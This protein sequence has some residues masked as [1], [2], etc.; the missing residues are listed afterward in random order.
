MTVQNCFSNT[1][2]G[3][4]L[5]IGSL[6]LMSLVFSTSAQS[7]EKDSKTSKLV[8]EWAEFELIEGVSEE[9][10]LKA[11]EEVQNT[12][13]KNQKGFVKRELL[14]GANNTWVDLVY[15]E[16]MEDAQRAVKNVANSPACLAYF[17]LMVSVDPDHPEAGI[18]H[19]E[20]W[21]TYD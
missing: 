14:K 5:V 3:Y 15:W 13:L 2:C 8:I 9:T 21:K 18:E 17:Q 12:F 1:V 11:S 6:I 4:F 19:Y 10:L 7:Q 20:Q 16:S